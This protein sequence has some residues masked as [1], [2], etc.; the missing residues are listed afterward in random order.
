M[1]GRATHFSILAWRTPWTEKPGGLQSIGSKESDTTWANNT[2][3]F[4]I[5]SG[6]TLPP[7]LLKE[8]F[9]KVCWWKVCA[10][11]EFSSLRTCWG[12]GFS[13]GA[14]RWQVWQSPLLEMVT[15]CGHHQLVWLP[16]QLLT[17]ASEGRMGGCDMVCNVVFLLNPAWGLRWGKYEKERKGTGH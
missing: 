13:S 3:T 9:W 1:K 7:C 10:K 11:R 4:Q 16:S 15:H 5:F 8:R 14:L 17:W 2:F 6:R 12:S